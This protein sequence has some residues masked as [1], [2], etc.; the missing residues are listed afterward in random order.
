MDRQEEFN[1]AEVP[2]RV[3]TRRERIAESVGEPIV[4]EPVVVH[5]VAVV[6]EPVIVREPVIVA[7]PVIIHEAAVVREPVL[8]SEPVIVH[9]ITEVELPDEHAAKRPLTE[10]AKTWWR[11]AKAGF[12]KTSGLGDGEAAEFGIV[13]SG[14]RLS[15]SEG[16][17]TKITDDG[18]DGAVV[19]IDEVEQTA[20][21][22]LWERIVEIVPG[23]ASF[24]G[25]GRPDSTAHRAGN[26]DGFWNEDPLDPRKPKPLPDVIKDATEEASGLLHAEVALA[27]TEL[28]ARLKVILPAVL[29]FLA[30]V[31]ILL[32]A[33]TILL[34]TIIFAIAVVLPLWAA[35]L[36]VGVVGLLIAAGL[37]FIGM[38]RLKANSGRHWLTSETIKDDITA[39]TAAFKTR[40]WANDQE[41]I[42]EGRL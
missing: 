19:V 30:A 32:G 27:K 18:A 41:K 2:R 6:S 3:P 42:K 22:G 25:T 14:T 16:H 4:A 21:G 36:I 34:W 29:M 23:V 37:A 1:E 26:T 40:N 17:V 38:R 5:E 10:E 35:A 24:H 39:I 11:R 31:T 9:E 20:K 7:E 28:K 33:L 12:E 15:S 8:V 13:E